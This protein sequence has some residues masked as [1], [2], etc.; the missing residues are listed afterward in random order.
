M[1][2]ILLK[3]VT[4][5][6]NPD[7]VKDVADGYARN[8]LFPRNLA[9]Q[10]NQHNVNAI[11]ARH[12]K[13]GRD[14]EKDLQAQQALASRLDG[15][16]LDL[17]EKASE[18][19]QLYAAVGDVKIALALSAKGLV[20]EPGQIKTRPIKEIGSHTILIKLRHGLEAEVAVN[21]ESSK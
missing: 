4:G 13:A 16:E 11:E 6:G 2:V 15:Y 10:A 9:V 7:D 8:F 14:A 5:L 21:I 20:I 12:T 3:K 19:G 1:K 18:K 17:K